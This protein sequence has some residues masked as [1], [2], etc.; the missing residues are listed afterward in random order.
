[1]RRATIGVI[2]Y[3]SVFCAVVALAPATLYLSAQ[4]NITTYAGGGG[5]FTGDGRPAIG[6]QFPRPSDVAVDAKGNVYFTSPPLHLV[7]QVA[8]DGTL[9]IVAG[10]GLN[11]YSGDGSPARAASLRTPVA[12]KLDP[13]GNVLSTDNGVVRSVGANGIITS[14]AGKG[15][16]CAASGDGGPAT[17]AV[18]VTVMA[19]AD[20]AGNLYIT[21]SFNNQ[22]RMVN[23]AGVISTVAGNGQNGSTG[24]GGPATAASFFGLSGIAVDPTGKIYVAEKFGHRVRQF[25]VGGAITTV[26]GTGQSGFTGDGGPATQASLNQPAGLALDGTGRLY[27]ADSQNQR[28]RRVVPGGAITTIAGNGRSAFQGD[29]GPAGAASLGTPSGVAVAGDG[30]VYVADTDNDRIRKIAVDGSITTIA[31]SGAYLGDGA[32][33]TAARLD[34]P[35]DVTLDPS[36]NLFI[37]TSDLRIRKVASSGAITTFAGTGRASGGSL[38]GPAVNYSFQNPTAMKADSAGNVYVSDSGILKIAPDGTISRFASISGGALAFDPAGNA[39]TSPYINASATVIK[40]SPSGQITPVAGSGVHGY[41]GDGGP[42][43]NASFGFQIR[44]LVVGPDGSVYIAD[45]ENN[46]VRKVDS[47]GKITLFAGNGTSSNTGDG[48]PAI[49]AG[50]AAPRGLVFDAKGN[51]YIG[52]DSNIIRKVSPDGTITRYVGNGNYGFSGDGGSALSAALAYPQGIALDPTGNLFLTD[53]SNDRIRVVQSGPVPFLLLSQKGLTFRVGSSAPQQSLSVVNSG[54]GTVNWAVSTSVASA[55]PNWLSASPSSGSSVAGQSGPV[56][57]VRADPSGLATGD[58]YGQVVVSAPGVPNSPQSVTVVLSVPA[59][60][61]AGGSSLQPAA[62]LFTGTP[63]AAVPPPQN[64][65]LSTNTTAGTKFGASVVFGDGRPWFAFQPSSGTVQPNVPL[66]IAVKPAINGFANGVYNAVITVAF[67]D[68]TTQQVNL[69]LVVSAGSGAGAAKPGGIS[70]AGCA[71]GK[72][73]PLFTSLGPGFSAIAGWPAPVE[74]RVVDDCG[75]PLVKGSVTAAFSNNDPALTLNSLLDGRWTGTWQVGNSGNVSVTVRATDAGSSISGTAQ[76]SGGLNANANPPPVVASGGVLD[77]ASYNLG[78]AVAPG[79]LVAIF[80]QYLAQQ[81]GKAGTLP[82][83]TSLGTTQVTLAG[84]TMPLLFAGANQVNAMIPYDLPINATHQ[85][86]V[87]RGT[88]ISIPEPVSVLSSQSG[89]F[90]KDLTGK[91]PGI[92]VKA[93][94]DGT[95]SLVA[96]DNPVSFND[97]IVIYSDGLGNVD[98]Q[99]IAGS[100]TPL[101]P[102]SRTLDA[103]AVS[104]GGVPARV[105]FAGLTPGFTGL[106]QVNAV[107]PSGVVPG[108][109]VPLVITQAGRSSPPVSI[110]VR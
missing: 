2:G 91:G 7:M 65:T 41:S 64:I 38:G 42:A 43:V 4:G 76:V 80:G 32:V 101:S 89:V 8:P 96:A 97:T 40:I 9:R 14:V 34:S 54:L 83:P 44:G 94:A 45:Y 87:K 67:D 15:G 48:G 59:A 86:V 29:G 104:I 63:G 26:A 103:V 12:V 25:T 37:L 73:L 5:Q 75:N 47:S 92:V 3:Q 46:R 82:L 35:F 51:L 109:N 30:S 78:A 21:D 22:V 60:G 100:E 23:K 110:S 88:T 79:S 31:G 49:G 20:S 16:C 61:A 19:V 62:L 77:A 6:A 55:G 81:E 85:I 105:F 36:G 57:T 108:D 71:P 66:T 56:V 72:L 11:S 27:I 52:Q 98:P 70:A 107:V 18:V 58:Y 53:S 24:D 1:M 93:A 17:S 95:Q 69:L 102:L 33:S 13:S 106:Y 68:N 84:R 99:A 39:Y 74:V 90:S 28:I 50:L 10:N